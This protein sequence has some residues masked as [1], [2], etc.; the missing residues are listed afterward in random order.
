MSSVV[1]ATHAVSRPGND[2]SCASCHLLLTARAPEGLCRAGATDPADKPLTVAVDLPARGSTNG[3]L[4]IELAA[5]AT[6]VM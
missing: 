2:V 6:S 3:T 1:Q 4:Q 5:L